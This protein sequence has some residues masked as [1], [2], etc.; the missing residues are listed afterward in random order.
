VDAALLSSLPIF[1]ELSPNQLEDLAHALTSTAFPDGHLFVRE[2]ARG[3]AVFLIESGTVAVTRERDG[4]IGEL[5]RLGPG[6]LFGLLALVD[7]EPRSAT[8]RAVGPVRAGVLSAASF[9]RLL[10]ENAPTAYALQRALAVQLASD[11]RGIDRRL[12][13]ILRGG[14]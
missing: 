4:L 13:E 14:R 3:D 11:F 6:A 12:R 10:Q 2:G 8:C 9:R 5:N 1:A 7:D